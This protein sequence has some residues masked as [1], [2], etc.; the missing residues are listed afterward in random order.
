MLHISIVPLSTIYLWL[1]ERKRGVWDETD[2]QIERERDREQECEVGLFIHPL[3]MSQG[4][5]VLCEGGIENIQ[6]LLRNLTFLSKSVN[7]LSQVSA[8]T[9]VCSWL[10]FIVSAH[11]PVCQVESSRRKL[12]NDQRHIKCVHN[13]PLLKPFKCVCVTINWLIV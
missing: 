10:I 13:F 6:Q 2:I 4:H 7:L 1:R 11:Q 3:E 8:F 5:S 12:S 9:T